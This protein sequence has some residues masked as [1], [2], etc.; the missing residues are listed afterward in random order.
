MKENI[1]ELVERLQKSKVTLG[2]CKVYYQD[3]LDEDAIDWSIGNV[4][5]VG[6]TKSRVEVPQWDEDTCIETIEEW[7]VPNEYIEME[8]ENNET[9]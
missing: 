8:E 1:Y 2:F 7:T 4:R 6:K 5:E 9:K 3:E